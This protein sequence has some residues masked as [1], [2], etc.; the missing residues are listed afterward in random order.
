MVSL[1]LEDGKTHSLGEEGTM[2]IFF[3]VLMKV[4]GQGSMSAR[5]TEPCE[6]ISVE[7]SVH[8]HCPALRHFQGRQFNCDWEVQPLGTVPL[9]PA[10]GK[11]GQV[12]FYE[13]EASL[14]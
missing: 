6:A 3:F 1:S 11:Q 2:T 5:F 9:S 8:H 10:L 14:V 13:S 12:E 7:G 4:S